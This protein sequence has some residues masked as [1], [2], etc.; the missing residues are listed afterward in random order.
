MLTWVLKIFFYLQPA[1]YSKTKFKVNEKSKIGPV[2]TYGLSK[3]KL[4]NYLINLSKRN[5]INYVILR[6][7]NVL[8]ADPKLKYGIISKKNKSLIKTCC[9][10][11]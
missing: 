4:E 5:K 11:F 7:F 6:Y 1:V 2:N 3:L 9:K 8:G 10:N